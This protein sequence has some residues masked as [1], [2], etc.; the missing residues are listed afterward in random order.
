M[1]AATETADY[2]CPGQRS[3]VS[4]A[5]HLGRL[6]RAY[7]G[8]R[9]CPHRHETGAVSARQRKQLD[10]LQRRG[11]RPSPFAEEGL[12][13][14]YL[15]DVD[16]DVARRAAVALGTRLRRQAR[17][18]EGPPLAVVAGDGR[19]IVPELLAAAVEGLRWTG[20]DVAE[21]G[22]ATAASTALAIGRLG[23]AG[24]LLIGKPEDRVQSVG[25]KFWAIG[26]RPLSAGGGLEDLRAVFESGTSRPTRKFG[27]RRRFQA[28]GP[29]LAELA[30]SYHALRPLGFVV[31]SDSRPA[32]ELLRTLTGD[33]A[34]RPVPCR[35]LPGQLGE[36]VRDD[37]AHFGVRLLDDAEC[38]E[39]LDERGSPVPPERVL[40]LLARF[41]LADRPGAAIVLPRGTPP[42]LPRRIGELG[43]RVVTCGERRSEIDVAM[44]ASA[45]ILGGTGRRLWHVRP[46]GHV[47]ADSLASLTLLLRILSRSDRPLSAVLDAEAAL[48]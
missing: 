14:D 23:A 21:L 19:A 37:G 41:L 22:A 1:P 35:V 36:Q 44:R 2:L 40:L 12:A 26:P 33:T 8:C 43:G 46:G 18:A 29:Y 15:N 28:D 47:A 17:G 13:G 16:P 11:P 6:A 34:C 3:P 42:A 45:A 5:V 38:W 4:R 39:V 32:V 9:G 7:A 31:Q 25:V 48:G 10:R 24:G 27:G 20:C 30:D